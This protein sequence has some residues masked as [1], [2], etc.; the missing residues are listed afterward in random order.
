MKIK[1]EEFFEQNER[2][3]GIHC[4]ITLSLLTLCSIEYIGKA[5]KDSK[6]E[7]GTTVKEYF[8]RHK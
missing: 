3:S 6:Y 2:I 8:M 5:Y 4:F 1:Q 7:H